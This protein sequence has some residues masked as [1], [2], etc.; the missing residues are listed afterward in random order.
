MSGLIVG[1]GLPVIII[2]NLSKFYN[3]PVR[4]TPKNKIVLVEIF[5][6]I[7]LSDRR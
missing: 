5:G 1:A 3:C 4:E 6:K 7:V 2:V